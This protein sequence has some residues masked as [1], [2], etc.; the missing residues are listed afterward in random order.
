[1]KVDFESICGSISSMHAE[2]TK[3]AERCTAKYLVD[4]CLD[5]HFCLTEATNAAIW[6]LWKTFG[7]RGREPLYKLPDLNAYATD[8]EVRDFEAA[9]LRIEEQ[10]KSEAESMR[11]L[12]SDEDQLK[13][14]S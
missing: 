13:L 5:G 11:R 4:L 9:V 1:M 12:R 14:W 3:V 8:A 10:L 7:H 6:R 2:P